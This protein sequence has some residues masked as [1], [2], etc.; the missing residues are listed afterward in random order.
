MKIDQNVTFIKKVATTPAPV[1]AK[2]GT[3]ELTQALPVAAGQ[4]RASSPTPLLPSTHGDF[5][6]ARV[7]EI[8]ESI[9][10]GRYQINPAKIADGLLATVQ[11]LLNPKAP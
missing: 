7:A 8:R 5:D 4:P 10:A 11:D 6:A 2:D 9:S 3:S 1:A